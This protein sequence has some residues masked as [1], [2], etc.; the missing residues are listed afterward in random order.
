MK[1]PTKIA[2][3]NIAL[4]MVDE[5]IYINTRG[6]VNFMTEAIHIHKSFDSMVSIQ[7][8]KTHQQELEQMCQSEMLRR[9]PLNKNI[10]VP[11]QF[12]DDCD[13]EDL[14]DL[15]LYDEQGFEVDN[16]LIISIAEAKI[17]KY[18]SL[19]RFVSVLNVPIQ[20]V[21][22]KSPIKNY[23]MFIEDEDGLRVIRGSYKGKYVYEID[24]ENFIGCAAGW[25]KYQ[26]KLNEE[27]GSE[28]KGALTEDDKNVFLDI[29]SNKM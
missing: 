28:R 19:K 17:Q 16:S 20:K 7:T 13:D 15:K 27:L 23:S 18:E 3:E 6:S 11:N 26:L 12:D 25:S 10:V 21:L 14:A 1:R 4:K 8:I 2:L 29:M 5:G 22:I 24:G 9:Y